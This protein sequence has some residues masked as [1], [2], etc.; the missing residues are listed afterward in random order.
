LARHAGGADESAAAVEAAADRCEEW[1]A[2]G[3]LPALLRRGERPEAITRIQSVRPA[4]PEAARFCEKEAEMVNGQ[5][6]CGRVRFEIDGDLGETR[7]C[8]CTLCRRANGSAFSANVAVPA[9]H[10]RLL[11]G[12]ELIREY[13]SSPGAF[14]AFCSYCGSPVFARVASDP[15]RIRVRLGTL[16]QDAQAKVT[17]HVWVRSKPD[18]YSIHDGLPQYEAGFGRTPPASAP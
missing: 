5:C 17:A 1:R 10:Y 11:V 18:W 9:E 16:D 3:E 8:Y 7:L 6:L 13:E 15:A 12:R 2:V 4:V 14:R